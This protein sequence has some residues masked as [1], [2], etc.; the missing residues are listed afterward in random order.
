MV[1][2]EYQYEFTWYSR[3]GTL[4]I[5]SICNFLFYATEFTLDFSY[6]LKIFFEIAYYNIKL[7]IYVY[8]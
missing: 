5:I 2:T 3:I 6:I 8:I 1:C 7:N 4:H